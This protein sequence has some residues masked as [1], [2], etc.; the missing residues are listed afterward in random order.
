MPAEFSGRLDDFF[1]QHIRHR[2]GGRRT[3]T[4][5][6]RLSM[7]GFAPHELAPRQWS[8]HRDLNDVHPQQCIAASVLYLFHDSAL[9][10]TSFYRPRKSPAEIDRLVR[11]AV[12]MDGPAFTRRYGIAPGYMA[13]S[14]E[15]FECVCSAPARWNRMVFYDGTVFHS[16]DIGRPDALST[17]PLTGRLTLNG[18]FSCSRVAS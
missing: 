6:C 13:G 15:F 3:L 18:F 12:S 7:V 14:N 16:G 5:S 9:G 8:C 2:L 11:D 10:G 17:D 1:R 4:M